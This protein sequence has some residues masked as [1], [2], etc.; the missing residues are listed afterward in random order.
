MLLENLQNFFFEKSRS[1]TR[2]EQL[3][4]LIFKNSSNESPWKI[5]VSPIKVCICFTNS[6]FS[7]GVAMKILSTSK[8][9][10]EFCFF[11]SCS[12]LDPICSGSRPSTDFRCSPAKV[13]VIIW[14][15]INSSA[16]VLTEDGR[17]VCLITRHANSY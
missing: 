17:G 11:I 9:F 5:I 2:S 4:C 15:R 10:I 16:I 1:I 12:K 8:L 13:F 7:V 3:I 14:S 6:M